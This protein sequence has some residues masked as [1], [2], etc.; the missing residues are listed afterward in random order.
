MRFQFQ[1]PL[2][3][4]GDYILTAVH[5]INRVPSKSLGN[6]TPYEIL[7]HA[8]P[9]YAHLRNFGCLCFI[10]TSPNH[11][12]KFAPRARKC[13]FLDYPHGIKG[14]K[15][16]DLDSNSIFISRDTVFYE[17]IFL[18][19][20]D[21]SPSTS[22]LNDFVFPYV[23]SD[24][25]YSFDLVTSTA[26][27][28]SLDTSILVSLNPSNYVEPIANPISLEV[29]NPSIS[30]PISDYESATLPTTQSMHPIGLPSTQSIPLPLRSSTR[31]H[32]PPSYLLDYSCQ[33]VSAK[34]QSGLPY[35]ISNFLFELF[36]LR[37]YF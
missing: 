25:P 18:Y 16:L 33:S 2:C 12:H 8:P 21:S 30:E 3:F 24:L 17:T 13:V 5:L 4:W 29:P 7:F 37:A 14:Y 10:S 36:S 28:H 20:F 6:K 11:R 35:T 32:V 1:V 9:F 22:Y 19:A 27:V 26:H 34:P 15:V 31:P 23:S